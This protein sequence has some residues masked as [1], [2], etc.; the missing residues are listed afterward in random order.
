M[1]NVSRRT[2]TL[3]LFQ[4]PSAILFIYEH[5]LY[6]FLYEQFA[7][8]TTMNMCPEGEF[9]LNSLSIKAQI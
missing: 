5:C 6:F 4:T 2:T 3:R 9:G 8:W 7:Y 1:G